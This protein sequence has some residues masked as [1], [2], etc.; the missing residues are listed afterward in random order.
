[1]AKKLSFGLGAVLLIGMLTMGFLNRSTLSGTGG[2]IPLWLCI[3]FAG[4]L[5][6]IAL[7]PLLCS[8]WWESHQP[9]AVAFWSLLF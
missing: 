1:M 7:C 9:W 4:L 2:E 6:C 3:P 5:L 8:A